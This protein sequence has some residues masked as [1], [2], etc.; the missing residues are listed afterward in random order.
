MYMFEA[1]NELYI[2]PRA[3]R[4]ASRVVARRARRSRVPRM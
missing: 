2:Q 1:I 3:A 4:R